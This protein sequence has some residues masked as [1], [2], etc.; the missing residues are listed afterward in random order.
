MDLK[1]WLYT[2]TSTIQRFL[3]NQGTDMAAALTYYTVLTIFPALLC[4]VSLMKLSGIGDVLVP[5]LTGLISQASS[6][7]FLTDTLVGL[8][9]SFF[10]SAGAGLGLAIGILA[11]AWAASGYVAAFTRVMNRAYRVLE[12]RNP[13]RLKAQQFALTIILLICMST[14]L[15]ALVVSGDVAGWIAGQFAALS[16]V[17]HLWDRLRWPITIALVMVL[18]DVL[19]YFCPNVRFPRFRPLSYGSIVAALA[20]IIAVV[21]F[22]FY[23]ANFGSYDATYGALAGAI[24]A[25]WLIW[26][27][28]LAL[29]AG[30][31]LDLE[32]LRTRQ[33]L[34]GLPAERAP[35]LP[36]KSAKGI[37]KKIGRD[38][39]LAAKGNELR[40]RGQ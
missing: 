39:K 9:E 40:L 8:I 31:H 15:L 14:L 10:S 18:I 37:D 32:V 21:G 2:I 26:L 19:Y 29:V 35:V 22:R 6:D 23:A 7:E 28:N 1:S 4:I 36:P 11:A 34:Q 38:N 5:K 30:A 3:R 16:G 24:I 12:G 27:T 25:L 13:V 17:V 20:G 33:L